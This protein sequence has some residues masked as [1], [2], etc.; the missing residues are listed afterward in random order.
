MK[1]ISPI[2]FALLLLSNAVLVS[3]QTTTPAT[4][5]RAVPSTTDLLSQIQELLRLVTSL[6]TQ[7]NTLKAEQTPPQNNVPSTLSPSTQTTS[8]VADVSESL[9]SVAPST[10]V[11]TH[12]LLRNSSGPEV[13]ELQVFLA[14]LPGIYPEGLITNFYGPLTEK[15]V[16]R[17]Q[18]EYG[19]AD[20][21]TPQTTG[22]GVVGIKTRAKLHELMTQGAGRSG[23]I[24]QGL[25]SAPG[26]QKKLATTPQEGTTTIPAIPAEPRGQTGTTTI[27]AVPTQLATNATSTATST[28]PISVVPPVLRLP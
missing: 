23:T 1:K 24:P 5:T 21:G 14:S 15:A 20:G 3:A 10:P 13:H 18:A 27:P 2:L 11:F 17:F 6:Q 22:Y 26:I 8:T 19:I 16:Q 28:L 25:L 7:L 12:V 4:T 9:V